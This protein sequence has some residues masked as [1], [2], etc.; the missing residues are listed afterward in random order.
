MDGKLT[1]LRQ[2][3]RRVSEKRPYL[4]H[5][6]TYLQT[7]LWFQQKLAKLIEMHQIDL[8]HFHTRFR[9]KLVYASLTKLPIPVL[10][11]LRDKMS[12]PADLAQCSQ[13]LLCCALGVARFATEGGY[14]VSRLTHIPIT[15]ESPSALPLPTVAAIQAH[16]G[17][18]ERP[19]LL[20]LGDITPNKGVYEL[21][22][23]FAQWQTIE[24]HMT[25]V[26][27]GMNREGTSFTNRVNQMNNVR[28]LGQLSHPHALALMQA[29]AMV[30]LP[31]RS[32]ALGSV[33]LEAIGLGKK[34]LCPPNIPE[35]ERHLPDFV[36]PEVS[37]EAIFHMIQKSGIP[38]HPQ[39]PAGNARGARGGQ[40]NCVTV[41]TVGR[42][43]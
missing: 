30:L 14:P 32:E 7:Q 36:L 3:P 37:S 12:N 33:I 24:P 8:V 29:A 35:F 13:H 17:L 16:F 42:K 22:D 15:F 28:F 27:A 10:A 9:G 39:L 26:L 43:G 20:Y 40:P 6:L 25:L 31:S 2:L 1:I 5:A 19:Y 34:V 18:D 41:P 23:A 38:H 21:L 4:I 11:D